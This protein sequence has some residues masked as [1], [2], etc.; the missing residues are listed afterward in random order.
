S[1]DPRLANEL[2][3][4]L[5]L[6]LHPGMDDADEPQRRPRRGRDPGPGHRMLGVDQQG[7]AGLVQAGR[8]RTSSMVRGTSARFTIESVC[9]SGG[10]TSGTTGP[11][12]GASR[13]PLG[14]G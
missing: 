14:G 4:D 13:V 9:G 11:C 10:N 3:G 1:T 8:V 12:W 6:A 7:V 2:P 5:E